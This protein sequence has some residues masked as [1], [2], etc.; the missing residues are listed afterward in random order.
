MISDK[1]RQFH[2]PNK[3]RLACLLLI[4]FSLTCTTGC[5]NQIEVTSTAET[6]GVALDLQ[7]GQPAFSVQLATTAD[8][9][10]TGSAP[11]KPLNIT[12][13][14]QTFT[15]AARRITLGLPRLPLWAHTGIYLLGESLASQDMALAADFMARNRNV[16]KTALVF[17]A[18]GA[19]GQQCLEAEMPV[20]TSIAGLK[21]LIT[22][23]EQE[24][25]YY[26]PI[27]IDKFLEALA[28]PGIDPAVP[29]V[30]ITEQN[31]KKL[32]RLDGTALF[33]DRRMVG[34]FN[35]SESQGYRFLSPKQITG[36]LLDGPLAFDNA[37]SKE[38]ARIKGIRSEVAGDPDILLV[39]DLEAGNMLAKQLSF[40]A[41]A[42]S[43]GLVLGAR[44]PIILTSRSD[45]VRSRIASCA[46][47][48][49]VAHAR[50]ETLRDA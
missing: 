15:E 8:K 20:D 13:T 46:V 31:G 44:V 10:D 11:T 32:L 37:I 41:Q 24:L 33:K 6:D 28:T 16:R 30:T 2:L 47:A 12:E 17:V 43:A 48:M 49:L 7:N 34:A 22:I 1:L 21:K 23:Q 9:K 25:G 40:L 26:Q 39:P 27:S 3:N 45:N 5:W 4:M 38:A 18:K 50:R 35:E 42:D 19:T 36:G 29:I 14:G